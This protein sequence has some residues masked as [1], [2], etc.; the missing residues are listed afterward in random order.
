MGP[1][2]G[3]QIKE[4]YAWRVYWS[5]AIASW[6]MDHHQRACVIRQHTPGRKGQPRA[7]KT[8][9]TMSGWLKNESI[10]GLRANPFWLLTTLAVTGSW[11]CSKSKDVNKSTASHE[12]RAEHGLGGEKTDCDRKKEA[13][14]RIDQQRNLWAQTPGPRCRLSGLPHLLVEATGPPLS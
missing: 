1:A 9:S 12:T 13:L 4:V 10:G 5:H 2:N 11:A 7:E 3:H 6:I 14:P 8:E